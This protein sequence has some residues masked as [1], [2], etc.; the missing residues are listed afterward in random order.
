MP[1]VGSALPDRLQAY[2]I[3]KLKTMGSNAYRCSHNPPTPELLD[4]CDRLGMLV[5]DETR[6]MGTDT[7]ALEQLGSLI[8]RDRNHPCVFAWSIGNEEFRDNIQG[9]DQLGTPI[10]KTMQDFAHRLDPSRL[11]T[12]AMNG[13]YGSG[14]ANVVDI[15]GFNYPT[16]GKRPIT[17]D[18]AH[19]KFPEK[20]CLGTEDASTR[21]TR[22]IYGEDA[23]GNISAT[24]LEK[25]TIADKLKAKGYVSAYDVEGTCTAEKWWNYYHDRPYMS[26][27][28][29]WTGFDYRG[30]PTPYRWP[31]T[32]SHFGIM[33]LCGFPKDNYFYYQAWWSDK[34]V[35]HLFPHWNWTGKEGKMIDVWVHSNADEVE[36]S[37]NGNTVGRQRS[38]ATQAFGMEG[39]VRTRNACSQRFSRGPSDCGRKGRND[40][41]TGEDRYPTGSSRD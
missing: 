12:V 3:E 18:E 30:E 36:L 6:R 22:G 27:S 25:G 16:R 1:G 7:E 33:D 10:A 19:A 13:A 41:R 40:R 8:R 32:T 29:V 17:S 34:P 9:D 24:A 4:A 5:L 11:C 39:E 2:R 38:R 23:E 28:F 21:C 26:G 35:V 37:L 14:F 20:P 15:M 31:C